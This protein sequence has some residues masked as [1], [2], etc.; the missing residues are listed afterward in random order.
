MFNLKKV[1]YSSIIFLA[2]PSLAFAKDIPDLKS[3]ISYIMDTLNALIPLFFAI[4]FLAFIW[5]IIGYLRAGGAAKMA[6]ARNY[7]IFGILA[8]A[9]MLSVFGLAYMVKNTFFE[10]APT[11]ANFHGTETNNTI[12]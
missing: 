2:L 5:G 7:I 12:D 1:F 9:V 6:E 10:S 11:P 8:M 3:L 4:A